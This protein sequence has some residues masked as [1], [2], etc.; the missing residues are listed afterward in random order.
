MPFLVGKVFGVWFGFHLGFGVRLAFF[1]FAWFW[2]LFLSCSLTS[3]VEEREFCLILDIVQSLALEAF[4]IKLV[5]LMRN[6]L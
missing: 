1:F 6:L 5:K 4:K 3:A 2:V